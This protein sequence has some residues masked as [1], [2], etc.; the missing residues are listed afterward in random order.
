MAQL[1]VAGAVFLATA[2]MRDDHGIGFAGGVLAQAPQVLLL[3]VLAGYL[4]WLLFSLP[5]MVLERLVGNPRWAAASSALG[6]AAV[7]AAYAWGAVSLWGAPFGWAVAWVAGVGALPVTAAWYARHRLLRWGAM[8][9]RIG[10]LTGIALLLALVGGFLQERT[11]WHAYEPPRLDRSRYVGQWIGAGG[12]YS[13]RLDENGEAEA[14]NLALVHG[15]ARLWDNCSGTGTWTF[16][17]Q[18][19]AGRP[20]A[21]G[22]R[23]R[24]TLSI[25]GCGPLRDWQ[26]A[27]TVAR[28]QLFVVTGD[29]DARW[30]T[31]LHRP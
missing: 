10:A 7:S 9:A 20:A 19:G 16:E 21:G 18:R 24:I 23:D 12:A 15:N 11:R 1:V 31:T 30:V 17:S 8:A 4:H 29:P 13:L 25:A 27:G 2:G 3:V 22:P 5:A 14:G 28:P 26:V 6:A